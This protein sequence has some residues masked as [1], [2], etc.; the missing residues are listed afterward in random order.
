MDDVHAIRLAKTQLRDAYNTGDVDRLLAI[1]AD[2]Y[3]DMSVG[4][5]SFYGAEAKAVLR[6]RARRLFAR[7]R[8]KLAVTIISIRVQGPL[9]FDWGWH[10]LTL[11]LKKSGRSITTRNRYL[12]IWQKEADGKWRIAIFL[13]NLDHPPQMPPREVMTAMGRERTRTSRRS[14]CGRRL[15]RS[16]SAA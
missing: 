12:E 3:S 2:G 7:Y 16:S 13:D 8:A 10:K 4:Q 1:F 6:H 9:A 11:T 14:P 15:R 5:P